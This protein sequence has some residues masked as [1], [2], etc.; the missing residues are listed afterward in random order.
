MF[1]KVDGQSESLIR[2]ILILKITNKQF[3]RKIRKEPE[4]KLEI[5]GI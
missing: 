4:K 5:H 1:T 3:I 2:K